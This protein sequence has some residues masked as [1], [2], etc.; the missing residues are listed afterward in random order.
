MNGSF[1]VSRNVSVNIRG[2]W[3]NVYVNSAL[4]LHLFC[5]SMFI[6]KYKNANENEDK[7]KMFADTQKLRKF[8]FSKPA[9]Q[10]MLK[11]KMCL[12]L[13]GNDSTWNWGS[14]RG[15]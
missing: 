2:S 12:S 13:K 9:L 1:L 14:V 15:N 10:E 6:S 5:K 8:I 7:T 4:F 11:S 3:W